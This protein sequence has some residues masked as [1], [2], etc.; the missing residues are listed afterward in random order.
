[1]KTAAPDLGTPSKA[2]QA[3]AGRGQ[4]CAQGQRRLAVDDCNGH[5]PWVEDE[6][7]ATLA[8]TGLAKRLRVPSRR[9][10]RA[11]LADDEGQSKVWSI[12][13]AVPVLATWRGPLILNRLHR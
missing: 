10:V 6:P 12:L 11:V 13:Q 5:L 4:R 3:V 7:G 1:M 9:D 2:G 8:D